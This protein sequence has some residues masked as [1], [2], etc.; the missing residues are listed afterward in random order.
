MA[1]LF[2]SNDNFKAQAICY[3]WTWEK[4]VQILTV[5]KTVN[6]SFQAAENIIPAAVLLE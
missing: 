3:F 2:S 4:G 5:W 6:S 1:V